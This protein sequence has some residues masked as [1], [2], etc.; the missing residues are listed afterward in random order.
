MELIQFRHNYHKLGLP[1][2]TTI[3]GKA[4]FKKLKVNQIV[5]LATPRELF[6]AKIIALELRKVSDMEIDFLKADAEWPG[7]VITTREQF[8]KLLNSFRAPQW[9]QVTLETELCIITLE[10]LPA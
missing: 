9:S 10:R 6:T 4:K 1:V 3:R 8:V 7:N 2:F 5:Q